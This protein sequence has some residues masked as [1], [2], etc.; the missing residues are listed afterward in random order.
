M[1]PA[2]HQRI[3]LIRG[4]ECGLWGGLRLC[5]MPRWAAPSA[6]K[7]LSNHWLC[8][9]EDSPPLSALG[10]SGWFQLPPEEARRPTWPAVHAEVLPRMCHNLQEAVNS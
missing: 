3:S 6:E 2:R 9:P 5:A 10:Q 4:G 1:I 7:V 8:L